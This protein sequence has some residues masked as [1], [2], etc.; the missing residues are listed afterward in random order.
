VFTAE[1]IAV[2]IAAAVLI[3]LSKTAL[4]AAGLMAV[5]LLATIVDGRQIA[6]SSLPLLLVADQFAIY[7]YRRHARWD[8][9]RP[10]YPWLAAGYAAGVGFYI[11]V[12]NG[13]RL[14]EVVIGSTVLVMVSIQ[15][16]RL[17]MGRPAKQA[18]TA[19]AAL[20]GS[21]GGF[22]TFVSTSGGPFINTYMV[23]LGLDKHAQVGTSAWLYFTLNLTK[24]PLYLLLGWL[25]HGGSFF[26]GDILVWDVCMI[27]AIVAGVYL[28][29][30]MLPRIPQRAFVLV[31]LLLSGLGGLKLLV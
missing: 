18:T 29:R 17:T 31:V 8:L 12:G 27:P 30:W 7:W 2:G 4:P 9:L 20:Y 15:L 22:S 21:S 1:A 24:L 28:G 13:A 10:L 23:G 25:T 11:A 3:G 5:P 19:G 16:W 6:G 14:I 26:T